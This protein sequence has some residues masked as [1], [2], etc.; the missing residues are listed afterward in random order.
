MDK[1]EARLRYGL[2]KPRVQGVK[3][4]P[5]H[6]A[7]KEEIEEDHMDSNLFAGSAVDRTLYCT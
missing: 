3:L 6:A 4:G 2:E 7:G 1:I 5:K